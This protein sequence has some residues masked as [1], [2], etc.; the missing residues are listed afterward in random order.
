MTKLMTLASALLMAAVTAVSGQDAPT[1]PQTTPKEPPTAKEVLATICPA[2]ST[3]PACQRRASLTED[4]AWLI[5]R[6]ACRENNAASCQAFRQRQG[7]VLF[8][9]ARTRTWRSEWESASWPLKFDVAG[10]PTLRLK[11][12]SAKDL[13][14]VVEGVS[15]LI[16][17]ATPGTPTEAD[18]EIVGNLKTFLSVAATGI[19]AVIQTAAFSAAPGLTLADLF[20]TTSDKSIAPPGTVSRAPSGKPAAPAPPPCQQAPPQAGALTRV[21]IDRNAKLLR[22]NQA[23]AALSKELAAVDTT[24]RAFVTQ[25]QKAADG[26]DVEVSSLK[27]VDVASLNAS[28]ATMQDAVSVLET[29]TTKL[30]SCQPLLSA[31]ALLLSAPDDPDVVR[32]LAAHV[33][34]L[35]KTTDGTPDAPV[36]EVPDV[37]AAIKTEAASASC[38]A[39]AKV[40]EADAWLKRHRA[41][42][43]PLAD[44]LFDPKTSEKAVWDAI[45][46]VQKAKPQVIASIDT[47]RR[48]VD[49][50]LVH[51]WNG[52][53]IPELV[54]TRQNPEL[55]WSKIQTHSI[56]VKPVSPYV[57]ELTLKQ[58]G[59]ETHTFKLESATGQILGYGIGVIYTPLYESTWTAAT[60][61]DGTKV[62]AETNRETRAGDL[63]AFLSYRFLEH[64]PSAKRRLAQ[65]TLDFGVGLT[66]GRPAFFLGGGL[67]VVRALRL[68]FGWTPQRVSTLAPDQ[69]VNVTKVSSNDDIRTVNRFDTRHW[70]VSL[71]FALDA[72]SLFSKS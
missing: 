57:K 6:A 46:A 70:Y 12:R 16:Y 49:H 3:E 7:G 47:L 26:G 11:P 5:V 58:T 55:R 51:S 41:A 24:R 19:Q 33:D 56:V 63:A 38:A 18:L 14:I 68:G 72:L 2:G 45:D 36:C 52:R 40:D 35:A 25:A 61:P 62:I 1:P 34:T 15:P 22:L 60:A 9:D 59:D 10:T 39:D 53:L 30:T 27:A 43:K 29:G 32:E 23:V 31:Y 37:A 50:A 21:I 13:K 17:S 48:Q 42:M 54:V 67:E 69:T 64:H 8:L 28:F 71:S 65:P 44:R 66:S 20:D 4:E